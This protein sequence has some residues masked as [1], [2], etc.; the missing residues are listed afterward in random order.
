MSARDYRHTYSRSVVKAPVVMLLC[1]TLHVGIMYALLCAGMPSTHLRVTRW[2][3]GLAL[4]ALTGVAMAVALHT[5]G[6]RYTIW[7]LGKATLLKYAI[8]HEWMKLDTRQAETSLVI[9]HDVFTK[10][11][12]AFW[13]SEGTALGL[14]RERRILPWDD[15]VDVGIWDTDRAQLARILPELASQGLHLADEQGPYFWKFLRGNVI[16]DV[17][18]TGPG[19]Y[20]HAASC[21]CDQIIPLVRNRTE[22]QVFNRSFSLPTEA[23]LV[24]LYTED[25]HIPRSHYKPP[26]QGYSSNC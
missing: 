7:R 20:C 1:S 5:R 15:D 24:R 25:W 21:P 23:Y 16:V 9:L 13:P 6:W 22:M 19:H 4:L 12:I 26:C 11:S 10:H 3:M 8:K 2:R 18:M 14:V 17:D